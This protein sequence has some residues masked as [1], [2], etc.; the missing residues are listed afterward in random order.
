MFVDWILK[1]GSY[2]LKGIAAQLVTKMIKRLIQIYSQ[3]GTHVTL[4]LLGSSE[5]DVEKIKN[6]IKEMQEV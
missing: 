1:P 5:A 4:D 3:L 6:V 2:V